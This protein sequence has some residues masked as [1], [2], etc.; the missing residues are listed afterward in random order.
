MENIQH[1]TFT[2]KKKKQNKMENIQHLAV[3]QGK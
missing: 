2:L 1:L 3:F